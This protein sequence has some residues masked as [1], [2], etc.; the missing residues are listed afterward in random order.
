MTAPAAANFSA[1]SG[2]VSA[3]NKGPRRETFSTHPP[4]TSAVARRSAEGLARGGVSLPILDVGLGGDCET[5]LA[6]G[7]A[8]DRASGTRA[9]AAILPID[10]TLSFDARAPVLDHLTMA[11]GDTSASE[12][13]NLGARR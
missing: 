8:R 11:D 10:H 1:K 3:V 7:E 4:P 5:N 13:V 12:V 9:T 6:P 2:H